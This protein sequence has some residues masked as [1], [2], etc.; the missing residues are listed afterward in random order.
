MD[1]N[2]LSLNERALFYVDSIL[3]RY[4]A[5]FMMLGIVIGTLSLLGGSIRYSVFASPIIGLFFAYLDNLLMVYFVSRKPDA[6]AERLEWVIASRHSMGLS[7]GF[8]SSEEMKAFSRPWLQ[9]YRKNIML[10]FRYESYKF[11]LIILV[12]IPALVSSFNAESGM[13]AWGLSLFF[14]AGFYVLLWNKKYLGR[15]AAS[16]RVS[17]GKVAELK[18]LKKRGF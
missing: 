5:Q 14:W 15:A 8:Q 17:S 1:I 12:A 13:M 10:V 6:Y 18:R 2:T 16:L 3:K 4:Y 7:T 11:F 9:R